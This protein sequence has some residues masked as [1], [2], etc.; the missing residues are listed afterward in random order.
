MAGCY[1]NS[2]EDRYW[3]KRLDDYL[4]SQ[5]SYDEI[6][7]DEATE[8]IDDEIKTFDPCFCEFV[9]ERVDENYADRMEMPNDIY[10][11][12]W[13]EW[14]G[15]QDCGWRDKQE[16]NYHNYRFE[17]VVTELVERAC[18][19]EPDFDEDAHKYD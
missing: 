17:D 15:A 6:Y 13:E 2:A 7:G 19:D 10:S 3:E 5:T 18:N 8:Q 14:Y 1:G 16:K 11:K 9:A 4:E 12:Q